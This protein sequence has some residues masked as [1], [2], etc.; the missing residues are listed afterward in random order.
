[1]AAYLASAFPHSYMI[2]V[3]K[4]SMNLRAP[5]IYILHLLLDRRVVSAEN[6]TYVSVS[7]LCQ[8]QLFAVVC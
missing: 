3:V 4:I 2:R 5:C 1:M 6:N 8:Q 7:I